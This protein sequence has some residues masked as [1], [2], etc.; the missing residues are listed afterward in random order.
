M[1]SLSHV[2]FA[3]RLNFWESTVGELHEQTAMAATMDSA[4]IGLILVIVIVLPELLT[5]KTLRNVVVNPTSH[6]FLR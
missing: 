3:L 1:P 2:A 4:R 6:Q 5:S